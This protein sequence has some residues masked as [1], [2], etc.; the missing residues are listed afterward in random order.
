MINTFDDLVDAAKEQ[1]E[2]QRLLLMFAKTETDP[3]NPS[4]GSIT[5]TMCIDK[6]PEELS[7]FEA[8]I[9][10]AD[11]IST[12]WD[13]IFCGGLSGTDGA[14]PSSDDAEPH[15]K[16]MT[17]QLISG[18]GLSQYLIFDRQEQLITLNVA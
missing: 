7:S 4:S 17:T 14:A 16:E 6:L 3:E 8:L 10:E 13:F 18:E 12:E 11:E 9:I 5:P 15:L 2:P 1:P